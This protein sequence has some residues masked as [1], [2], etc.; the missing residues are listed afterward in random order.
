MP[1]EIMKD[2]CNLGVRFDE[3][4]LPKAVNIIKCAGMPGSRLY[5]EIVEPHR[6]SYIEILF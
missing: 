3:R 1:R 2:L 6:C 5:K 4:L